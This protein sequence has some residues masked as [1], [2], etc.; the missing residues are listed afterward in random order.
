MQPPRPTDPCPGQASPV[1]RQRQIS[2]A[3]LLP[4]REHPT[5]Q[6]ALQEQLSVG[7]KG[8]QTIKCISQGS[9]P[10][11]QCLRESCHGPQWEHDQ[12]RT[13]PNPPETAC[14][15]LCPN[16]RFCRCWGRR[17]VKSGSNTDLSRSAVAVIHSEGHQRPWHYC[18][19]IWFHLRFRFP[20]F[21]GNA[22]HRIKGER[23]DYMVCVD[24]LP[25]QV[26]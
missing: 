10:S 26:V 21:Y 13:S 20:S 4:G 15:Q 9:L 2:L 6:A 18:T 24:F 25:A 11:H 3:L 1:Q 5:H 16:K 19:L 12:A 23:G 7:A 17:T 22:H 14:P 8:P